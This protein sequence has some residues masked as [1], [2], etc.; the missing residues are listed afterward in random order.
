MDPVIQIMRMLIHI[1]G[2][3]EMVAKAN[4]E[5]LFYALRWCF[6]MHKQ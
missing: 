3:A 6:S 2:H 4:T 5:N 1:L